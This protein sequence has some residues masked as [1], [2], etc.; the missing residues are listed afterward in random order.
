MREKGMDGH[1]SECQPQQ[2][3][4]NGICGMRWQKGRWFRELEKPAEL[5]KPTVAS[6]IPYHCYTAKEFLDRAMRV[7]LYS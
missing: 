4:R 2:D 7:Y 6:R 1:R 5:C 3:F